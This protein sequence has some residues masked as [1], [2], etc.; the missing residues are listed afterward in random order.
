MNISSLKKYVINLDHRTDR[1]EQFYKDAESFF[2]S[3]EIK[4]ITRVSGLYAKDLKIEGRLAIAMSFQKAARLA[5]EEW[6]GPVLIMEDDC[7]Y[8][9]NNA[10]E[11]ADYILQ[12]FEYQYDVFK[13][14][15]SAF[16][17]L[18]GGVYT[19]A[20][21]DPSGSKNWHSTREFSSTHFIIYTKH[22]LEAL[23]AE[24]FS[25]NI[26]H[27]DR[28]LARPQALNG[29]GFRGLVADKFFAVQREGFSDNVDKQTHYEHLLN[30]FVL[31]K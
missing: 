30:R 3:E 11:Y 6:N 31:L 24:D 27:I 15:N 4:E 23:I 1:L 26:Q 12:D 7:Y 21:F 17:I 20:G 8:P 25:K 22:V 2:T 16:D 10:R 28:W 19:S 14:S 13:S 5:L 9:S 18:I 29:G